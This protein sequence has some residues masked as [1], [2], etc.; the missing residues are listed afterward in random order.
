MLGSSCSV[1]SYV[2][3]GG[4]VAEKTQNEPERISVDNPALSSK[5]LLMSCIRLLAALVAAVVLYNAVPILFYFYQLKIELRAVLRSGTVLSEGELQRE[6]I[7]RARVFG[8]NLEPRDIQVTRSSTGVRLA[9]RYREQVALP[10]GSRSVKLA[11]LPM[12]ARE[13]LGAR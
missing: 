9:V 7:Q 3:L 1:P 6:V 2:R 4:A 5:W 11:E 8:F 13:E 10:L 12:Q